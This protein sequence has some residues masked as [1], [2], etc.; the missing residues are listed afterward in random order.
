MVHYWYVC[1]SI[2]SIYARMRFL[3]VFAVDFDKPEAILEICAELMR[4]YFRE[5]CCG[6]LRCSLFYFDNGRPSD[7][8]LS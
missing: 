3:A 1:W 7:D 8:D 5:P 2:L 6:K 4:K